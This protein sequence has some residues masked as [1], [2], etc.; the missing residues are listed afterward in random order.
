MDPAQ[1]AK[2]KN[3]EKIY[4][5]IQKVKRQNKQKQMQFIQDSV[6]LSFV[7][8][9]STFY[10]KIDPKQV[11]FRSLVWKN[12]YALKKLGLNKNDEIL[13]LVLKN[14]LQLFENL[15][16]NDSLTQIFNEQI[17]FKIQNLE[18]QIL[19]IEQ[20]F[21][22]RRIENLNNIRMFRVYDKSKIYSHVQERCYPENNWT[23]M[24][25][26]SEKMIRSS[27]NNLLT[28]KE[29]PISHRAIGM[30]KVKVIVKKK[31]YQK[32]LKEKL[33]LVKKLN[34]TRKEFSKLRQEK[35]KTNQTLNFKIEELGHYNL[36][37]FS[38]DEMIAFSGQL[39]VNK[40]H[41]QSEIYLVGEQVKIVLKAKKDQNGKFSFNF[42][43]N[44]PFI[45][46]VM[47]QEYGIQIKKFKGIEHQKLGSFVLEKKN[48]IEMDQ[49]LEDNLPS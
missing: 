39:P 27:L 40:H 5:E 29:L 10:P 35:S 18:N 16:K 19:T 12:E 43:K 48:K 7:K 24:E 36:D 13:D 15:Q 44:Q 34:I 1:V 26:H 11:K 17:Q 46:I 31:S 32:T 23:Y 28:Y 41:Q 14:H 47:N 22:K 20:D 25:I 9:M 33:A 37:K 38:Q 6:Q 49:I 3:L 2:E 45:V 21:E 4:V 30:Q 42:S 8:E